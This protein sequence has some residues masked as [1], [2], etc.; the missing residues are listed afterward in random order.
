MHSLVKHEISFLPLPA[1]LFTHTRVQPIDKFFHI[2][3]DDSQ[4]LWPKHVVLSC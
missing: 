2:Q 4:N 3:P 1:T